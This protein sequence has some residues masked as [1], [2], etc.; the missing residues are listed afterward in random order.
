MLRAVLTAFLIVRLVEAKPF[1]GREDGGTGGDAP[2]TCQLEGFLFVGPG[3]AWEGSLGPGAWDE[4]DYYTYI[5]QIP[6]FRP[7]V[8]A[9]N[10]GGEKLPATEAVATSRIQVCT[11]GELCRSER[12]CAVLTPDDGVVRLTFPSVGE[13]LQVRVTD[14]D[15]LDVYWEKRYRL[16]IVLE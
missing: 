15:L 16:G 6:G 13:F 5:H 3:D 2:D 12:N 4:I 9:E 10:L 1:P 7:V 11:T 8:L 14:P